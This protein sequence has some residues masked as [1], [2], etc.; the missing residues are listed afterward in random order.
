MYGESW[1]LG[2]SMGAWYRKP[3]EVFNLPR[4][5]VTVPVSMAIVVPAERLME[6]LERVDEEKAETAA[7]LTSVGADPESPS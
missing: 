4:A 5:G 3:D 6:L 7:L 2:V 1:F